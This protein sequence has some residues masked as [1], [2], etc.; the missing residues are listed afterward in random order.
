MEELHRLEKLIR[1]LRRENLQG[2]NMEELHR[3]EKLIEGSFCR[4]KTKGE[5]LIEENQLS[6]QQ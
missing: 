3:L 4:V 2:L 5:E 6:K 1:K